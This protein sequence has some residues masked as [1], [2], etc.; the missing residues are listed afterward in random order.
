MSKM[1]KKT[2][3][4]DFNKLDKKIIRYDFGQKLIEFELRFKLLQKARKNIA[5]ILV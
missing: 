4:S 3:M 5:P 1:K 2:V